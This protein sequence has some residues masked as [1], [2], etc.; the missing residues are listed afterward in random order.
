MSRIENIT[1]KV[2]GWL[3]E[4]PSIDLN[5]IELELFKDKRVNTENWDGIPSD[6]SV[7]T[8]EIDHN[9]IDWNNYEEQVDEDTLNNNVFDIV[10]QDLFNCIVDP[11]HEGDQQYWWEPKEDVDEEEK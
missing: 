7:G 5:S 10:R 9:E 11:T 8:I 1:I 2:T 6:Y 3:D 4:D